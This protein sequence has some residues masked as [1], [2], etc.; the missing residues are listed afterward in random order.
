MAW[1]KIIY[2]VIGI[3]ILVGALMVLS[4]G[5]DEK[6]PEEEIQPVDVNVY[7][8]GEDGS[9]HKLDMNGEQVWIYDQ[10]EDVVMGVDAD[11]EG[12]V[13][14]V[15]RAGNQLHKIDSNGEQVWTNGEMGA[16]PN[17]VAVG[18]NGN[19]YTG[20]DDDSAYKFSSD[21]DLLWTYDK[22]VAKIT[23]VASNGEYLYTGGQDRQ[24][25]KIDAEDG[26]QVWTYKEHNEGV[27]GITFD[28]QGNVYTA[29]AD[30]IHK[31]NSEGKQVWTK[32]GMPGIDV[33]VAYHDGRVYTVGGTKDLIVLNAEDGSRI[34]SYTG[35]ELPIRD[36]AVDSTGFSY[37]AGK[38]QEVHK[39]NPNG[40]QVWTYGEHTGDVIEVAVD[41]VQ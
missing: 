29:A 36:V 20:S 38:N 31:V 9:V 1:K 16:W 12:N 24:V 28:K 34:W 19:I 10:F 15:T 33:K 26:S 27:S 41:P 7:T 21:G 14:G 8:A 39:V 32:G 23:A 13:Y 37:T 6:I 17:A 2:G 35:Q 11:S 22:H 3:V 18:S 4:G 30:G 5:E 25:H 40:E